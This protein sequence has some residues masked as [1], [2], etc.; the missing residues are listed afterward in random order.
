MNGLVFD[1][2][3][4]W[5]VIGALA[6]LALLVALWSVW[7]GLRGWLWR[8][9]AGL[10]VAAALAGPAL[11]SG[12]RHKLSDIVILLDDRSASQSLPGR[13]E[14]TD[15][16]VEELTRQL[17]ALPDTEIRRVT[18]SDD[19]D[20]TQIGTALTRALAAEPQGRV[21]GAIAVTDGLAHDAPMLPATAPGPVHVLLTGQAQDWD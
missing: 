13:A 18:V 14:Q 16:A 21:A 2:L 17:A 9:A 10:A 7:Q 15:A 4:P 12:I 3:L 5:P 8:G 20:G 11:E 19:P 6:V 1:P